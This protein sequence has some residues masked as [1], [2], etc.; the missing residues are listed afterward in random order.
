MSI[1]VNTRD[2]QF[3]HGKS[4]RGR[5]YWAFRFDNDPEAYWSKPDQLY[6][7]ALREART[8]ALSHNNV[9]EITVCP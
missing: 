4:P 7:E 1:E 8:L 6:S 2:Y 9:A 3:A 5:G